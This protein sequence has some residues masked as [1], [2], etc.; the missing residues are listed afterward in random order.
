MFQLRPHRRLSAEEHT[1]PVYLKIFKNIPKMDL[2]MLLPG[3]QVRMT[4]MDRG[5]ILLPTVSGIALTVIKIIKGAVVLAYA[6]AYGLIGFFG[7]VGGTVGYGVKSF[8]GYLR[9]REKYQLNLTKNLYYQNLDNNA[10]VLFRLLDEAEEQE[11]REAIL[12]WFLLWRHAPPSGWTQ[13][14][15]DHHAEEFLRSTTGVDVDFEVHDALAKLRRLGLIV[16][17]PGERLQAVPISDALVRLD[18]AWDGVFRYSSA[19]A[20]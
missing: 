17:L 14:M 10:G 12:A 18:R 19:D 6:G 5:R 7:L 20:A 1:H 4:L 11:F 8:F 9:T 13:A 15:L 3:S 16:S 2:E